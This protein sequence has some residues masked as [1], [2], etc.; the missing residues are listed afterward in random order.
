MQWQFSGNKANICST[1]SHFISQ[2][3]ATHEMACANLLIGI[4][5]EKNAQRIHGGQ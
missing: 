3:Q 2:G 5:S 4:S 1:A